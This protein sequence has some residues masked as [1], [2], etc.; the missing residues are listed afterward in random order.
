MRVPNVARLGHDDVMTQ[1]RKKAASRDV[2]NSAKRRKKDRS[3][4]AR[5]AARARTPAHEWTPALRWGCRFAAVA[6]VFAGAW[7]LLFANELRSPS[8]RT[9]ADILQAFAA[10]F[11]PAADVA[12]AFVALWLAFRVAR[13]AYRHRPR[14]EPVEPQPAPADV[15]ADRI[16]AKV[17]AIV[18]GSQTR[19]ESDGS[20]VKEIVIDHPQETA[21]TSDVTVRLEDV[22]NDAL[23][24]N[25]VLRY[26]AVRDRSRFWNRPDPLRELV[27]AGDVPASV[28][29]SKIRVGIHEDGSPFYV[30][31]LGNH[32]LIAGATG[33]GK[34]SI[35]WAVVRGLAT[36]IR[37]GRVRVISIDPKGG[38]ELGPGEPLWTRFSCGRG[39]TMEQMTKSSYARQEQMIEAL[40]RVVREMLDRAEQFGAAG[41]RKPD[42]FT[43]Q[44]PFVVVLVD[45]VLSLI[46]NLPTQLKTRALMALSTIGQVGRAIGYCMI[47]STQDPRMDK[48]GVR[49]MV[50]QRILLRVNERS[51]VD[52][53][54]GAGARA[55]GALADRIPEGPRFAGIGYAM[56]DGSM[57]PERFRAEYNSDDDIAEL[58]ANY[59]APRESVNA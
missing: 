22:L 4:L 26:D 15:A 38:M 10:G 21:L 5:R 20:R 43:P 11:R 19:V 2:A 14:R 40:E 12:A 50:T 39:V 1:G 29:L 55:A 46:D 6:G 30:R 24:L 51:H 8:V 52:M 18:P 45:E 32:Y 34:G 41:I 56:A 25:Y 53:V 31:L 9:Y 28:D 33:A 36:D 7:G 58:V 3:S 44:T 13:F 48:T 49:G 16:G 54:L 35:Q 47:L 17:A 23:G 37:S 57:Q 42:A 59:A 27:P